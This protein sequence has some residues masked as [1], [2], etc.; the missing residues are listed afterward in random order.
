M[1]KTTITSPRL[2]EGL[3]Q[4]AEVIEVS[5]A[6]FKVYYNLFAVVKG[7]MRLKKLDTINYSTK[8]E[9][10]LVE[11]INKGIV[12]RR[13]RN[14]VN[15]NYLPLSAFSCGSKLVIP[16]LKKIKGYLWV[17]SMGHCEYCGQKF[18]SIL[19]P[20]IDHVQPVR[21]GG[22]NNTGNYKLCCHSC[23]SSKG[24]KS[25]SD[26][27]FLNRMRRFREKHGV[28]FNQRQVSFLKSL[29]YDLP[30]EDYN[31]FFEEHGGVYINGKCL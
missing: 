31:F 27:R 6:A 29:K 21:K 25:I 18:V 1:P 20:H 28:S 9:K 10:S 7:H 14:I 30:L 17:K 24:T 23:N 19:G 5:Y 8:E 13:G 2:L 4:N 3:G 11:L 22:T 16:T 15:V 26:F 12:S